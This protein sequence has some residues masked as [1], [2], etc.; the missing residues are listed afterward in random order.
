MVKVDVDYRESKEKGGGPLLNKQVVADFMAAVEELK[1]KQIHLVFTDMFRSHEKQAHFYSL[2]CNRDTLGLAS[3]GIYKVA[4]F[5]PHEVGGAFDISN[6][7]KTNQGTK[8]SKLIINV[9]SNHNF[10]WEGISDP[11]HF[12]HL[13]AVIGRRTIIMRDKCQKDWKKNWEH[14]Y[15]AY[16]CLG[17]IKRAGN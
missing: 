10:K 4:K 8:T 16:H 15:G 9:F 6:I 7:N 17:H 1:N 11:C 3:H 13:T 5:S 2:Y 12:T 14:I